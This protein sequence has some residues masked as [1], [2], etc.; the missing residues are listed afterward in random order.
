MTGAVCDADVVEQDAVL[1]DVI[2]SMT[3]KLT[4]CRQQLDSGDEIMVAR[5]YA[6]DGLSEIPVIGK[7]RISCCNSRF[8]FWCN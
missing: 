2:V 8:H 1:L 3:P 4:V 5:C 6:T 7:L